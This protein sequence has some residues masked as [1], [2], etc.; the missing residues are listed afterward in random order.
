MN[1]STFD[2]TVLDATD[3]FAL[4]VLFTL[5][6]IKYQV[7]VPVPGIL[8]FMIDQVHLGGTKLRTFSLSKTTTYKCSLSHYTV[9]K[10]RTGA[11]QYC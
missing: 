3:G 4:F 11:E 2:M 1:T 10:V 7:P 6:Q 5:L 8:M 9:R